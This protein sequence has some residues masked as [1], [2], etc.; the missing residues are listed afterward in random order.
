M[1]IFISQ[2]DFAGDL[3][4]CLKVKDG[5]L[6]FSFCQRHETLIRAETSGHARVAEIGHELAHFIQVFAG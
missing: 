4:T 2:L 5:F 6:R 3:H 1:D